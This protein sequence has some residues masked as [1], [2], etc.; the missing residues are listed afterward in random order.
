MPMGPG[1][2]TN[3]SVLEVADVRPQ[4][5]ANAR[6]AIRTGQ[7]NAREAIRSAGSSV[8]CAGEADTTGESEE[9]K[10]GSQRSS[11]DSVEADGANGERDNNV[12]VVRRNV[13]GST[14]RGREARRSNV[15]HGLQCQHGQDDGPELCRNTYNDP[16]NFS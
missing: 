3:N 11:R 10:D 2:H 15:P 16:M 6:E 7:A 5:K 1:A 13:N 12:V 4:A 9:S 8:D 14:A